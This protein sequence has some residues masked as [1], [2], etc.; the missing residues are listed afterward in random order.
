MPLDVRQLTP[1]D[2]ALTYA[3]LTTFGEAFNDAGTYADK[4][5]SAG[6]L[7]GLLG[8]DTFIALAAL[9]DDAVVG[10]IAAY[11]LRKFE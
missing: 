2:V 3:L 11:E 6:Y 9:K 10:G 4:R 7:R 8:A 5:P 1:D